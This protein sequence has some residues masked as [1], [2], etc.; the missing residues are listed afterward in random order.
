MSFSENHVGLQGVLLV[1]S[2]CIDWQ[3]HVWDFWIQRAMHKLM[4]LSSFCYLQQ[5]WTNSQGMWQLHWLIRQS[6][7]STI[8][9]ARKHMM[10]FHSCSALLRYFAACCGLLLMMSIDKGWSEALE[11]SFELYLS[12]KIIAPAVLSSNPRYVQDQADVKIF[13][14]SIKRC[15]SLM[16]VQAEVLREAALAGNAAASELLC[17]KTVSPVM[18]W[19]QPLSNHPDLR[20]AMY[21]AMSA[22]T[23]SCNT[24][25][26]KQIP[27]MFS[28]CTHKQKSV[29]TR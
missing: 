26:S 15:N 3:V 21:A 14:K 10:K 2:Q 5:V 28:T 8:S 9:A 18:A 25:T 13:Y 22:R 1:R 11:W 29:T 23:A 16:H 27:D 12:W 6:A 17:S 24:T 4:H 19:S 7:G 20:G